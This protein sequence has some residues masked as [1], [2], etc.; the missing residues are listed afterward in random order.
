MTEGFAVDRNLVLGSSPTWEAPDGTVWFYYGPW[1]EW[2]GWMPG[3]DGH[4]QR[5]AEE[6]RR[7]YPDAPPW[8]RR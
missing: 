3:Q 5:T 6:F 7:T 2:T 1:G 4:W 8:E